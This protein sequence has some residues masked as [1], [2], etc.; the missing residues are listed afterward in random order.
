MAAGTFEQMK[1]TLIAEIRRDKKKTVILTILFAVAA[2]LVGRLVLFSSTPQSASASQPGAEQ[3]SVSNPHSVAAGAS[4][5]LSELRSSEALDYLNNS[6][7]SVR[8]DLF[9]PN[10]SYFPPVKQQEAVVVKEEPKEP[11]VDLEALRQEAIRKSIRMAGRSLSLECTMTG[12]NPAAVI[13]GKTV[14][15]GEW[16]NN[17][18][19]MSVTAKSCI[20]KQKDV[21]I[22]LQMSGA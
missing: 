10:P 13:N 20:V 11:E 21:E 14:R 4:D 3:Y 15:V 19:L 17:F 7:R 9:S 6:E 1:N 2:A 22:T 18:Q 5:Q 16:I 8:R 12:T